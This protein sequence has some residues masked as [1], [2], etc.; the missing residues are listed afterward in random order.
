MRT[1]YNEEQEQA[2]IVILHDFNIRAQK[3]GDNAKMMI[4]REAAW[5]A[6]KYIIDTR[7]KNKDMVK[8][9]TKWQMETFDKQ[10]NPDM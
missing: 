1:L 2:N 9:T 3:C 7:K 8:W 4:E 5:V 10:S 6:G